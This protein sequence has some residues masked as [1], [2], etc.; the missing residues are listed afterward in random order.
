MNSTIV[1]TLTLLG[2]IS[3]LPTANVVCGA[4][5]PADRYHQRVKAVRDIPG[6]AAFWDFVLREEG[7]GADRRFLAHTASGDSHR[8]VLEPRNFSWDY[9]R[10]GRPATLADF[11]LLGRGPFGQAV[12]FRSPPAG[13]LSHLP[14][15]LVPRAALNNTPLDVKGPGRSVSM[16]VWLIHQEGSHAI[17]GIWHEGTLKAR[18]TPAV[19]REQ[20]RR[21][22]ALFAGLAA[23][24]GAVAMHVSENGVSSFG[25][26][27]AR[28]L[29]VTPQKM[30]NVS[31]DAE[32][33][34]LDAGWQAAGFVFDADTKVA[35]AY[36]DGEAVERWTENPGK[37][38]FFN[39]AA[40]AWRQAQ[41]AKIPGQQEGEDGAFPPDQYY[42]P[43]AGRTLREESI[44]ETATERTAV[45]VHEFTKVRVVQPRSPDGTWGEPVRFE[46]VALK[47]NPY[48]FGH[49]IHVPATEAE[50][51]PFTIGR[52]LHMGRSGRMTAYLGGVAVYGRALSPAEMGRLAGIAKSPLS[53]GGE[54]VLRNE[55]IAGPRR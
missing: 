50:G 41:L 26:I 37:D 52:V 34:I 31:L 8:Y 20:G 15:L 24:P 53:P 35:T 16:V 13:D 18:G 3:A 45:R 38:R 36:L 21:Q 49:S 6:L 55:E 5:S 32:D 33:E 27:Y 2:A 54:G 39:H 14:V 4:D 19:V 48:W 47:T 46:L 42:D 29:A 17:A 25:D 1:K 23:N 11:P 10:E 44:V 30:K 40:R 22:Y 9:W 7:T 43:P 51:G 28:H 12:L